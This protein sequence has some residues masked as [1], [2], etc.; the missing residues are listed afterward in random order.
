MLVNKYT[1]VKVDVN[2]LLKVSAG[3]GV[4]PLVNCDNFVNNIILRGVLL[5][6]KT[7]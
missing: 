6:I 2:M 1:I 3:S 4:D 7:S 5:V